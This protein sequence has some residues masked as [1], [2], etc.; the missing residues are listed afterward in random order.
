[1]KGLILVGGL[2]TQLVRSRRR[3]PLCPT[4][5]SPFPTRPRDPCLLTDVDPFLL[6]LAAA[7]DAV[8]A[9]AAHRLW[10][11]AHAAPPSGA[12][13][14]CWRDGGRTGHQLVRTCPP[15]SI[16]TAT[17]CCPLGSI[18]LMGVGCLLLRSRAE[19]MTDFLEKHRDY[20]VKV[21]LSQ[22]TEPLGTAGPIALAKDLLDDGEPFFVL[23]CDVACDF[24]LRALLDFHNAV[25]KARAR[26]PLSSC[27]STPR[28]PH[29][30]SALC[31]RTPRLLSR[32]IF[33][34]YPLSSG[35]AR[36]LYPLS[37]I[38]WSC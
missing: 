6:A 24:S 30:R 31:M 34:L 16:R 9:K 2:G 29:T 20:G 1:M 32:G 22:E 17:C 14:E 23:N 7:A 12:T 13:E 28:P 33:I 18:N 4:T 36:L 3:P 11:P 8:Q 21:T 38:L 26:Q 5:I 25:S 15:E 19:I 27:R 35:A 37:S 10:Q